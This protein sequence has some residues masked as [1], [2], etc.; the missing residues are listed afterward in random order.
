M[1]T[2]TG[3]NQFCKTRVR[4]L[5]TD[6]KSGILFEKE[7][8]NK[9]LEHYRQKESKNGNDKRDWKKNGKENLRKYGKEQ[10]GAGCTKLIR[11][12]YRTIR[13]KLIG[14]QFGKSGFRKKKEG[15]G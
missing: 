14:Q 10:F 9:H 1:G 4:E 11:E 7:R 8:M 12:Q 13:A 15:K 3:R 2:Y 6:K 5:Q